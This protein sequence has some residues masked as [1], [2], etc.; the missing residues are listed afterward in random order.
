[1]EI[2]KGEITTAKKLSERMVDV[3]PNDEVFRG[4]FAIATVRLGNLARYYLKALHLSL[5]GEKK[6]QFV[7]SDD[8]TAVNLEHILPVTPSDDWD[9]SPD[10]AAANYRRLGNM[11]LMGAADNVKIG[12]SPSATNARLIRAARFRSPMMCQSIAGGDRR[13]SRNNKCGWLT[14]P[15]KSGLSSDVALFAVPRF[16]ARL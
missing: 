8:T 7:P 16:R 12:T 6:P 1:M 13:K 9:I 10:V 11:V 4:A 14:W 3:V 5:T 15:Q 2:S